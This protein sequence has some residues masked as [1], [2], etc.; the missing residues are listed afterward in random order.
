MCGIAGYFTLKNDIGVPSGAL[1]S[2]TTCLLHRG[3]DGTGIY[4]K[5]NVGLGHTRLAII[6][7]EGGVQPMVESES[8]LALVLNGEI[9]NY[10]ELREELLKFGH[11]FKTDSDTEV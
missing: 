2:M 3:P 8:N 4:K 10:I 6:D 7:L 5:D 9:Y 1:E 11:Q